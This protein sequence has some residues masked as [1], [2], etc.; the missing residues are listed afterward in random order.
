MKIFVISVLL[1]STGLAFAKEPKV[2]YPLTE[3]AGVL[4]DMRR[5]VEC[6]YYIQIADL[7]YTT[8]DAVLHGGE[9]PNFIIGDPIKVATQGRLQPLS[10]DIQDTN[11]QLYLI[12][13]GGNR[14]LVNI[15][16]MRRVK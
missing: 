8:A 7:L 4:V 5:G 15:L 16:E 6:D 9:C 3:Y 12:K 2:D 10:H 13:D 11:K 1:L 14:E